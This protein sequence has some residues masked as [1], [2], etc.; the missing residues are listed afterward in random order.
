MKLKQIIS[1]LAVLLAGLLSCSFAEEAVTPNT[2]LPKPRWQDVAVHDP[3]IIKAEDGY[4][5]IYG[6]HMA[7]A[8]S[9]DL[10]KWQLISGLG[11]NR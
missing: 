2:E 11:K 3:S 6:S 10:I 4:Y 8:R 7:A 1:V 9:A 5:Y